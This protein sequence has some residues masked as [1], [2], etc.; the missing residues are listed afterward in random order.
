MSFNVRLFRKSLRTF[1]R[2]VTSQLKGSSCCTGVSLSQCHA[3]LEIE[4]QGEPTLGDL[5]QNLGLDKSTLSRTIDGLVTIGL[6]TRAA[7]PGDRR[8]IRISITEQGRRTCDR[9]NACNDALYTRMLARID[10][11]LQPVVPESFDALVKAMEAEIK[12]GNGGC[13]IVA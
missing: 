2:L 7:H 8:S 1:E 4:D 11:K 6:V 9:I 12:A 10:P 13:A 5:A 3:L